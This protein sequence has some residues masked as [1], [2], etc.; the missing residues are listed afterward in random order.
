M[1]SADAMASRERVMRTIEFG[2]PDRIPLWPRCEATAWLKYGRALSELF[3]AYPIDL[4]QTSVP[5]VTRRE[6]AD[7]TDDLGCVWKRP[8]PGVFGSVVEH[9][10][11]NREDMRTFAFPRYDSSEDDRRFERIRRRFENRDRNSYAMAG[12]AT[13]YGVL[14]YR[15]QWLRGIENALMDTVEEEAFLTA[16]RDRILESRLSYLRR[17]LEAD[18]DGITFGDDW[19]TQSGLMISPKRWREV[20]KPGYKR[21]FDEVHAAGKHVI[22]ETD[23]CTTAILDEWAEVGVDL[24][25][26]QLNV[27]GLGPAATQR[28]KIC[29]YADPDRQGILPCGSP[30]QV[31]EHV[32]EIVEALDTPAGGLVGCLYIDDHTPLANVQAALEAFLKYGSH[33]SACRAHGPVTVDVSG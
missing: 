3:S 13:E 10:L 5:D 7:W 9:P 2:S 14:W 19:G 4:G 16:L 32:H 31:D 27:V 15:M 12:G 18:V 33:A 8:R 30:T 26:V 17:V 29:F 22:M 1:N 28:G 20:F 21:L 24:L 6:R 25:S 23:G 11:S